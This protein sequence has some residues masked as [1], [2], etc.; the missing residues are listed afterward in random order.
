MIVRNAFSKCEFS[1]NR[2]VGTTSLS[3]SLSASAS[4]IAVRERRG[5][6]AS[7]FAS[8]SSPRAASEEAAPCLRTASAQQS[9]TM[10]ATTERADTAK[11]LTTRGRPST[12]RGK[13]IWICHSEVLRKLQ[14]TDMAIKS[15]TFLATRFLTALEVCILARTTVV[16]TT[17]SA[18]RKAK[19]SSAITSFWLGGRVT[20]SIRITLFTTG[21][22]MT[23][24]LSQLRMKTVASSSASTRTSIQSS[25]RSSAESS[26]DDMQWNRMRWV[27]KRNKLRHPQ[28]S[29]TTPPTASI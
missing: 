21:K 24:L 4:S 19:P 8:A 3:S 16:P 15:R 14:A 7:G 1:M 12:C 18:K 23:L 10:M 22:A 11:A 20:P 27:P 26:S 6:L 2:S 9:S 25:C 17:S 5:V 13:D 29:K 28:A